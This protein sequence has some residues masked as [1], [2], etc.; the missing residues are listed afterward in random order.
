M[1]HA[2]LVSEE[3]LLAH[4][5]RRLMHDFPSIS[6]EVVDALIQRE[7]ARFDASPI[8]SYIPLFVEKHAREQLRNIYAEAGL[9]S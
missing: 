7:H 1:S 8:R 6:P 3:P 9:S 4:V 5:E 2:T